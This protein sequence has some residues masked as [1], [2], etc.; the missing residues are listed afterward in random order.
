MII[1]SKFSG[2]AITLAKRMDVKRV[3]PDSDTFKGGKKKL[4]INWGNGVVGE[5]HLKCKIINRPEVV[6]VAQ[7]KRAS[8]EAFEKGGVLVP[9]WTTD[10]GTAIGWVEDGDSVVCR[11]LLNAAG[12]R[13]IVIADFEDDVVP[14]PLYVKYK[15]KKSEFRVHVVNGNMVL[16]QR[17][18]RRPVV[19]GEQGGPVNWRVRSH[20][21]GFI[22]QRNDLA[23]SAKV[24]PAA[25]K[26]MEAL[27]LDFGAV[28]IIYNEREDEAY[29][30]EVNTAPGLEGTTVEDYANAFRGY[31]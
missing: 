6:K 17:K 20:D 18:I 23:Y 19:E 29:V 28:D 8:M 21:N 1:M 13:G 25:F 24:V 26:A 11:T 2:G 12:G 10:E 31:E 30:L 27:N 7:C 15:K 22:F 3:R 16:V 5:E 9:A 4:L 14:A